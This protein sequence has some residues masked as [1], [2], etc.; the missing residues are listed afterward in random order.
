MINNKKT[1]ELAIYF[2]C[3]HH[4]IHQISFYLLSLKK[5]FN[6]KSSTHLE[7]LLLTWEF[8]WTSQLFTLGPLQSASFKPILTWGRLNSWKVVTL[9]LEQSIVGLHPLQL[10]S[11][12]QVKL[13]G[14]KPGTPACLYQQKPYCVPKQETCYWEQKRRKDSKYLVTWREDIYQNF[15][16]WESKTNVL[17]WRHQGTLTF[18]HP[19]IIGLIFIVGEM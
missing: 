14:N 9:K 4:E 12:I 10:Q 11:E 7:P 8:F 2:N 3:F 13:L 15:F 18:N 19:V 17:D 6:R 1:C 5:I 16:H